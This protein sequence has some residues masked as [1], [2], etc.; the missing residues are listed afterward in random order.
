MATL[1]VNFKNLTFASEEVVKEA[2]VQ[3][4][5]DIVK[6]AKELSPVDT[7]SLRASYMYSAE[8]PTRLVVGSLANIIN[9]KTGKPATEYASY[10][11]YGTENSPAQPHFI[12]AFSQARITFEIRLREAMRKVM[13]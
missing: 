12:P 5:D 10:V 7:G 6:M 11:E 2:L 3:T 13:K 9:P 1:K 4:A 8:T